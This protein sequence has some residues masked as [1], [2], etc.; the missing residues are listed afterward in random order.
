MRLKF[1][2]SLFFVNTIRLSLVESKIK[3]FLDKTFLYPI[4]FLHA[5]I[6]DTGNLFVGRTTNLEYSGIAIKQDQR[7]ENLLRLV[8]PL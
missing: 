5:Y 8:L 7:I 1:S 2:I 6:Q 3:A 4:N